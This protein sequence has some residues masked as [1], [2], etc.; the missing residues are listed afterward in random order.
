ME[1]EKVIPGVDDNWLKFEEVL[2]I[3]KMRRTFIQNE[4][5]SGRLPSKK[6][7]RSRRISASALNKWME[8]FDG[9]G[10]VA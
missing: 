8:S 3:T 2:E 9:S 5:N 6:V 4:L 10:Q 7:G 1:K